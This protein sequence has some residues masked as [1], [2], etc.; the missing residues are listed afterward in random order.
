M[1]SRQVSESIEVSMLLTFIGGF[2]EIYSFLLKGHVFATAITGNIVMMLFNLCNKNFS[3]LIKYIFPILGFC[4]GIIFSITAKRKLSKTKL[5]WRIYVI[6]LEM[7]LVVIIYMLRPKK[8]IILDICMISMLSAIQIQTFMKINK[9]IYMSTM[10]TGN[11]R[12]F[13]QHLIYKDYEGAKIFGLI[14][15]SFCSGVILGGYL[16]YKLKE[17]SILIMLIPLVIVLWLVHKN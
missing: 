2:L 3:V 14:I 11:T 7:I 15:T 16:I 9:K 12:K 10:C 5:H 13:I 8:L 17:A 6:V 1:E 4:T